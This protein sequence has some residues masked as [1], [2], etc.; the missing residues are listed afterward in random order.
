MTMIFNGTELEE[1]KFNG[2]DCEKV[3]FNGVLVFENASGTQI[4]L[5]VEPMWEGAEGYGYSKYDGYGAATPNILATPLGNYSFDA[6]TWEW[7]GG[8]SNSY[9]WIY[10]DPIGDA[11]YDFWWDHSLKL[12]IAGQ[13]I[14]F[15]EGQNGGVYLPPGIFDHLPKS[16]THPIILEVIN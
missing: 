6:L 14:D 3:Y 5:T 11:P 4:M 13:T 7:G 12:H 2:V 10:L 15:S 1:V 8:G 16:G 9:V